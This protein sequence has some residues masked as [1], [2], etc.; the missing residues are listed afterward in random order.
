MW[1]FR[2]FADNG[3]IPAIT[4]VPFARDLT[5]L[6]GDRRNSDDWSSASRTARLMI[7][8]WEPQLLP[9]ET[10][11]RP[12]YKTLDDIWEYAVLESLNQNITF[13][14]EDGKFLD[15]VQRLDGYRVPESVLCRSI[16]GADEIERAALEKF[17]E[18]LSNYE[19]GG[20]TTLI[21]L[22]EGDERG[23]K[24]RL[25]AWLVW[26]SRKRLD[27]QDFSAYP[28]ISNSAG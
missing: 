25:G 20:S 26:E 10:Q 7:R 2:T 8:R 27:T 18:H 9:N 16:V 1:G 3:D 22:D 21:T 15:E 5:W 19:D 28:V 13:Y 6:I 17:W 14:L 24:F 4:G 11:D 23:K 12:Q